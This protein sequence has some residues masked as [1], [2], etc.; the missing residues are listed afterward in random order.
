MSPAHQAQ[1]WEAWG[2]KLLGDVYAREPA[3]S[4]QA[5]DTYRQAL[6]LATELGLRPLVAHCHF[7]LSK[8][9]GKS[10]EQEQ[11]RQHLMTATT[12]YREM[13]MQFWL[14]QAEVG[15]TERA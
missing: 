15:M 10:N 13:G 6:A 7:G 8:L 14:E 9:Y 4:D 3:D 12:M 5:R 1:G 2:L 11:T